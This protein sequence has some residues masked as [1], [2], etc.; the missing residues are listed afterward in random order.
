MAA[1]LSAARKSLAKAVPA[2]DSG[3][4]LG[5]M[6]SAR[7]LAWRERLPISDSNRATMISQRHGLPELLGR[8]I[9]ARGITVDDTPVFLDPTLK[10]LM[11]DPSALQ[12]MD[13][14][15]ARLA[16]AVQKREPVAIF[17]DYD[18]DGAC[19]SALMARFFMSH[20]MDSRIYIPD[21]LF[22]G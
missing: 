7:G 3:A 6:H 20:G 13:Q 19:S 4:F 17:G 11:P 14:T 9:A 12:G 18:V 21:R 2:E 5:V 1:P 8:V 15:A 22:E 16:D 10:A